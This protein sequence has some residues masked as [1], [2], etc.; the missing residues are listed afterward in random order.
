MAHPKSDDSSF[1]HAPDLH[2]KSARSRRLCLFIGDISLGGGTERACATLA[3]TMASAGWQVTILSMYA[4]SPPYFDLPAT[5]TLGHVWPG[6]VRMRW[7]AAQTVWRV[8]RFLKQN[9]VD[10][11]VDAETSLT[12]YSTIA[13]AGS[14]IRHVAWENFHLRADLGS[15]MRRLGRYCAVHWADQVVLL[16]QADQRDWHARFG[17][18]A[19]LV[20]VTHCIQ[21]QPPAPLP[22]SQ[23]DQVILAVGRLCRQKGFDLLLHSWAIIASNHPGWVLR[24]VGSGEERDALRAMTEQFGL[25]HCVQ[26]IPATPEVF[27][28]YASASIYALSSRFEGFGLVL[29]E[30]MAQGLPIV[31]FDCCYGPAEIVQQGRTGQL[32][33]A[34]DL[35]AF[36]AALDRLIRDDLLR[37]RLAHASYAACYPFRKGG[38]QGQWL[39][40]LEGVEPLQV[41]VAV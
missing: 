14:G 19:K 10:A 22:D 12:A 3:E 11:W 36:A 39:A 33:P 27:S 9:T 23:R 28:H 26:W 17:N 41:P 2:G 16:T 13:L 31:A 25:D 29:I 1:P 30:A 32:V 18:L 38:N 6:R 40:V 4:G 5:V 7:R 21:T 15:C 24:I 8:R 20:V 35:N 37:Q 34:G